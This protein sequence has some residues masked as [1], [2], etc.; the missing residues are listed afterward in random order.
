MKSEGEYF[1][2]HSHKIE[3]DED[4][5]KIKTEAYYWV[6]SNSSVELGTE[7]NSVTNIS[8]K[9]HQD[10]M[11]RK[12][13]EHKEEMESLKKEFEQQQEIEAGK[14]RVAELELQ[15][16]N[17]KLK[18]EL[19]I[20]AA[21]VEVA[22]KEMHLKERK[23]QAVNEKWEKEKSKYEEEKCKYEE[24]K[25]VLKDHLRESKSR[26]VILVWENEELKKNIENQKKDSDELDE[27][28]DTAV[29]LRAKRRSRNQSQS[30][31]G[32]SEDEL[33]N[34]PPAKKKCT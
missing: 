9:V 3:N 13:E 26:C 34:E 17:E 10:K 21:K 15:A 23:L 6:N 2:H 8:L 14:R 19:K 16:E 20:E 32:G 5:V 18:K 31:P 22:E 1:E 33:N 25:K 24:E 4:D 12:E 11:K 28:L 7:E 29:A 30:L 27:F